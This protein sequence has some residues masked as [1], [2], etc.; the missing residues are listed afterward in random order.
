MALIKYIHGKAAG[1]GRGTGLQE[2][3]S[4]QNNPTTLGPE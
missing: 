2:C 3:N 1:K 4:V